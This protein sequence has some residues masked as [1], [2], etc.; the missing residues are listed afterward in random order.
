[1]VVKEAKK[2]ISYY[3]QLPYSVAIEKWDD[4]RGPY[5]VARVTELPHCMI[6]GSTPEEALKEIEDVKQEWLETCLKRGVRIPEPEPQ[7]YS[8]ELRL[9]MPTSLHRRLALTAKK[10]GVSLNSY[11]TNVLSG[12]VRYGCVAEPEAEYAAKPVV[13]QARRKTAVNPRLAKKISG[14]E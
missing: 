4:G 6:T 3:M 13:K 5:Y 11:I 14:D 8:G 1:M 10:E 12:S 9:R 7:D 2:D